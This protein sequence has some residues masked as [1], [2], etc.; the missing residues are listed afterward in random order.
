MSS[1]AFARGQNSYDFVRFVAAT[2]VLYSH[3]APLSGLPEPRVPLYGDKFGELAVGMFFC[4]SGF[5]IY[6]SL[7]ARMDWPRYIAAR[8][9]RIYPNLIVSLVVTALA[10]LIYF[11][12]TAQLGN[13]AAYVIKNSVTL[14]FGGYYRVPGA[15][16]ASAEASLNGSLWTMRYE[17]LMYILLPIVFLASRRVRPWILA[18]FLLLP[19]TVWIY[20][21]RVYVAGIELSVCM[22]L[23]QFFMTGALLAALWRYWQR[24]AVLFGL[25]GLAGIFLLYPLYDYFSGARALAVGFAAIGLGASPLM[26]GFSKG[27]DPSYG[28]YLFAWPIQQFTIL[29]VSGIWQS[30]A[31]AFLLTTAVGYLT[32]HLFE[33][34]CMQHVDGLASIL[35]PIM[36]RIPGMS[37]IPGQ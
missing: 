3:H 35:R 28:M 32:W 5:L 14:P 7:D 8:A 17:V 2:L 6:R 29:Y 34:R 30:M 18:A 16:E 13:Y 11:G 33:K 26:K 12:N 31:V 1:T 36:S 9:L 22:R 4:L 21:N 20:E 10:A 15:F 24:H 27:G 25:L 19:A 23:A 37:K